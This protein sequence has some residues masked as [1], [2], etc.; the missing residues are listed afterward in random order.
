M[1]F[2]GF[3]AE[4]RMQAITPDQPHAF[5]CTVI[6]GGDKAGQ[7]KGGGGSL[8]EAVTDAFTQL[9]ATIENAYGQQTTQ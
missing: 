8:D 7:I 4:P 9:A 6:W 2:S 5:G 1:K 3:K